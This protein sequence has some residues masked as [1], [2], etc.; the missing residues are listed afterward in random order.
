[1]CT[2]ANNTEIQEDNDSSGFSSDGPVIVYEDSKILNYSV[3]PDMDETDGNLFKISVTEISSDDTLTCVVDE[4]V[5]QFD[6]KLKENIQIEKDTYEL[7]EKMLIISDIE[8][9]FK[10]FQMILEGSGVINE[11]FEWTF[12][13]G[14]LVLVGDFF[15]RGLNV[16]ECL[17]LI[18]KLENEAEMKGG[19]VHFILG[20]HE[21]MVLQNDV[22]YVRK[23]YFVNADSLGLEYKKWYAA[24]TEL[25][26]WLRSKNAIEN[27]GGYLFVHAGLSKDVPFGEFTLS[28]IN[29]SIRISIDINFEREVRRESI[30]IGSKSPIWY[31]GI[32]EE[33]ETQAEV[34]STLKI[35]NTKKM[36]LGHTV[37][38]KIK[39]L[40]DKKVI[41]IDL[42]H[43]ENS[44]RGVMYAL[45]F[46]GGEFY[47]IDNS[48]NKSILK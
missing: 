39:Y 36:V 13:N 45:Y 19:K 26:R 4:S 35:F 1:M 15:D 2:G 17:W 16:N 42:H 20:N 3:I 8:G 31:R 48:G 38:D 28:Q 44:D 10:G 25:G 43:Q 40:Y 5:H 12:G 30:F 46:E 24:N 23:K 14:H 29:D 32:M 11:E 7:P 33:E 37:V 47:I 22:R 21:I 6:F 34:D 41:G 27:I 9:N 18:Y